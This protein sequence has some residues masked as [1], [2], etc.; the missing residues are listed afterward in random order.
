MTIPGVTIPRIVTT[1]A[2][3][4]TL[5]S[6][7][8]FL[9]DDD[10]TA[11]LFFNVQN[12]FDDIEQGSEYDEFRPSSGWST[13]DYHGRLR[14]LARVIVAV[15]PV[16]DV[17]VLAEIEN[18][19]VL[20]DLQHDFLIDVPMEYRAIAAVDG[21]AIQVGLLTRYPIL[22][23]H[24]HR[25]ADPRLDYPLRSI[26]EVHLQTPAERL[27]V[28]A[29]H[30]KSKLGGAEFTESLRIE[31]AILVNRRVAE[32]AI[33]YP[34]VP[35]VVCGDFNESPLEYERTGMTYATA[36]MPQD[37]LPETFDGESALVIVRDREALRGESLTAAH[38]SSVEE[39]PVSGTP[40]IRF[41]NPWLDCIECAVPGSY[42]YDGAWEQIDGFY[43]TAD[44]FDGTGLALKTF[45]VVADQTTLTSANEPRTWSKGSGGVSDHLPIL[46]IL[47]EG[48][49][50]DRSAPSILSPL[51]PSRDSPPEM[52]GSGGE[53]VTVPARQSKNSPQPGVALQTHRFPPDG[54]AS[55]R[56]SG[57]PDARRSGQKALPEPAPAGD[58]A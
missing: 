46:L 3:L 56:E 34:G 48:L 31:S 47:T 15:E 4:S 38:G 52:R 54:S 53:S 25:I 8:L 44:L 19:R 58:P 21:S 41:F 23:V 51:A 39:S 29:N 17:I 5:T 9:H 33:R 27:V 12:I 57:P 37:L 36:I 42:R 49:S 16:V 55:T 35:V 22:E 7:T 32:L 1:V 13:D 40:G 18:E 30:W 6:C 45:R 43:L 11:I 10:S 2:V 26:L 24:S 50:T 20:S 14:S 28:L